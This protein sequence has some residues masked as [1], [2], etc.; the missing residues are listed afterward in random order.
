MD[1]EKESKVVKDGER[2]GGGL[3]ADETAHSGTGH[4]R[5]RPDSPSQSTEY[6]HHELLPI[7]R[8]AQQESEQPTAKA[9]LH[10]PFGHLQNKDCAVCR[11]R[12]PDLRELTHPGSRSVGQ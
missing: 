9:T 2:N 10:Y 3:E 1:G 11:L 5:N 12:V 6:P 8:G 7:A 4:K